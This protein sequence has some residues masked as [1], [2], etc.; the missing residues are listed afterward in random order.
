MR[1]ANAQSMRDVIELHKEVLAQNQ[2]FINLL[3]VQNEML[4]QKYP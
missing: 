3:K 4:R 2:E 1:Q